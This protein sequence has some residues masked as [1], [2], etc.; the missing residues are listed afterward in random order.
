MKSIVIKKILNAL[1]DT[2]ILWIVWHNAH[3]SVALL[4]TVASLRFAVEDFV[5]AMKKHYE[6][7]YA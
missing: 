6:V 2:W 1:L 5:E 4:L 3:W 7:E